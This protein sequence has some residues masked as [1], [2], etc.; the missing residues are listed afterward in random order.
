[1]DSE[2]LLK[3]PLLS[4]VYRSFRLT[5]VSTWIDTTEL[6]VLGVCRHEVIDKMNI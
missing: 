5:T 4:E 3:V 6:M 2:R 1:M